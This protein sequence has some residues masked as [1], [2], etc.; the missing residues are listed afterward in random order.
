MQILSSG[1]FINLE[2]REKIEQLIFTARELANAASQTEGFVNA[3]P[4]NQ[5]LALEMWQGAEYMCRGHEEATIKNIFLSNFLERLRDVGRAAMV[6]APALDLR[7]LPA[8]YPPTPDPI[9]TPIAMPPSDSIPASGVS[10]VANGADGIRETNK[11]GLGTPK[12][13]FLGIVSHNEPED[14]RRSYSDECIPEGEICV[15]P[16]EDNLGGDLSDAPAPESIDPPCDDEVESGPL[17]VSKPSSDGPQKPP[18]PVGTTP[19]NKSIVAIVVPA[20][21][22]YQIENCTVKAVLQ[23]LPEDRGKRKCVISIVTH[24]F[25]PEI[26]IAELDAGQFINQLPDAITPVFERYKADFPV[27]VADELKKEQSQAKKKSAKTTEKP[28]VKTASSSVEPKVAAASE[29]AGVQPVSDQN[30]Q[31]SS[32]FGS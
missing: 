26:A 25:F 16:E 32:L 19:V 31:Q 30:A 6:Q 23:F 24:D 11:N 8:A 22:P 10:T 18:Q 28:K 29:A 17:E 1:S 4:S 3:G 21:E 15:V 7:P 14:T 9:V 12:D 20:K 13:E 5:R 27:K 2:S